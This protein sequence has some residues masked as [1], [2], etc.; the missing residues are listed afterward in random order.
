MCVFRAPAFGEATKMNNM[1]AKRYL[2]TLILRSGPV[3]GY[4]L[5]VPNFDGTK[6]PIKCL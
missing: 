2:M 4:R 5:G 6:V 3:R 1:T